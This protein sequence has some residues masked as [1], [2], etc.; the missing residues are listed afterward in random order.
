MIKNNSHRHPDNS[1][2]NQYKQTPCMVFLR[3][4]IEFEWPVELRTL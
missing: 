3:F 1:W 2:H 4:G